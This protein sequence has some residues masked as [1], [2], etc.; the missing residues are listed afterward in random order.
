MQEPT[1]LTYPR[2]DRRRLGVVA[3]ALGTLAILALAIA[4]SASGDAATLPFTEA[5]AEL[6]ATEYAQHCAACHGARLEGMDHFPP[7]AG[8]TFQHRWSERTL[9]ELY[10]YVHDLMPLGLGASLSD[11][12]YT[13][14]VV[15]MLLRNGFEPGEVAFDPAD[16]EQAA[17]PLTFAD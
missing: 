17:L 2:S 9:G 5:Q 11:E 12:E 14:I 4:P 15:Y 6:G 10:T 3:A 8:A 16:E 13:S 1:T 7:I